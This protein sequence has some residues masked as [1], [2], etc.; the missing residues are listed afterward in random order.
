MN[1]SFYCRHARPLRNP[2]HRLALLLAVLLAPFLAA[3]PFDYARDPELAAA[4]VNI[5]ESPV[6]LGALLDLCERQTRFKFVYAKSSVP[7]DAGVDLPVAGGQRLSSVLAAASAQTAVVFKRQNNQIGLRLRRDDDQVAPPPPS[8]ADA[9]KNTATADGVVAMEKYQVTS[10]VLRANTREL[11]TEMRRGSAIS[12]E[13]L[14]AEDMARF[15]GSDVSDLMIRIPGVSTSVVGNFAVVRGLSERYNTVTF[16]GL[17]LPSSDPERQST[18]LDQFPSRLLDG[19]VVYKNFSPELPGNLSGGGVELKPLSFPSKRILSLTLGGSFDEGFFSGGDFLTYKTGGHNDLWALGTRDR[20]STDDVFKLPSDGIAPSADNPFTDQRKRLPF[21]PKFGFVYGDTFKLGSEARLGVS[22]GFSYDS[23]YGTETGSANEGS[24]FSAQVRTNA[25]GKRELYAYFSGG[26]RSSYD[27]IESEA[28]VSLGFLA[29]AAFTWNPWNRISLTGFASLTGID[30]ARH[31]YNMVEVNGDM[32]TPEAAADPARGITLEETHYRWRDRLDYRE[33]FL[34]ALV[35]A[36]DH[37][38]PAARDGTLTWSAGLAEA[39]QDQPDSRKILYTRPYGQ[40]YYELR[41]GTD[42]DGSITRQWRKTEEEQETFQVSWKQPLG[43]GASFTFGATVSRTDRTYSER[44]GS[45]TVAPL[46]DPPRHRPFDDPSDIWEYARTTLRASST[47]DQKR[48]I[49]A[50]FLKA[51][52]PLFSRRLRL[53]GGLRFEQTRLSASGF[54]LVPGSTLSS[55]VHYTNG[56]VSSRGYF[57]DVDFRGLTEAEQEELASPDIDQVDLLPMA[58]L[59]WN[60]IDPL[61]FRLT[62]SKTVAR[63]SLREIGN[64]YTWNF[65]TDRY[66]HG[67]GFLQVSDVRNLDFR[68]EYFFGQGDLV[69]LSLFYKT[70]ERPIELGTVPFPTS[71]GG[72]AETWFNNNHT[73]RLHGMEFEFRKNLGFLGD[74]LSG[75]SLGGNASW[76]DAQVAPVQFTTTMGS[77]RSEKNYSYPYDPERRLYDQPEWLANLDFTWEIRRWGSSFTLAWFAT[78]RVLSSVE[79]DFDEYLDSHER[80]DL[81]CTQRLGKRFALK[82]SVRNLF[83]PERRRIR[84]K[85]QTGGAIIVDRRWHDGR[86]YTAQITAEF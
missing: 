27:Y 25:D 3:E 83:D 28:D 23:S 4:R 73:A 57:G 24:T 75:L 71:N 63:P 46:T 43:R 33:R 35:L 41:T 68:A 14:S 21:G 76:I 19:I 44:L 69:A 2:R 6:T 9:P 13:T 59:T 39:S 17:V 49:N 85:D 84:D 78:D 16:N 72:K 7:L 5:T 50:L 11:F 55:L 54:G 42:M 61:T 32:P 81:S 26:L 79:R 36:G 12:I 77:V 56:T 86:S 34:G 8:G 37:V 62:A 1:A 67:N 53:S 82:L 15:I 31:E 18:E 80:F 30:T 74:A 20:I 64:Y 65:D 47:V 10:S 40:D 22:V 45:A 51:E 60:P 48:S 38:F 70:I 52:T 29:N 58:G 66:Q